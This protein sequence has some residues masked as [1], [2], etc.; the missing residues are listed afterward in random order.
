MG[1]IK[2]QILKKNQILIWIFL[3]DDTSGIG[4]T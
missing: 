3:P 4:T 1:D 2:N